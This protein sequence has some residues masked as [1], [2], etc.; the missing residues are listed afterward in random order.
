MLSCVIAGRFCARHCFQFRE[1]GN[2]PLTFGP[3][4]TTLRHLHLKPRLLR[5]QLG[6]L[7][8][9]LFAL[10]LQRHQFGRRLLQLVDASLV[11]D[12]VRLDFLQLAVEQPQDP[13]ELVAQ[14]AGAGG[15]YAFWP[16][17]GEPF[18][19][20]G[21]VVELRQQRLATALRIGRVANPRSPEFLHLSREFRSALAQSGKPA[22]HQ[23]QLLGLRQALKLGVDLAEP[24][25][26]GVA[27]GDGLALAEELAALFGK[28]GVLRLK[29]RQLAQLRSELRCSRVRRQCLL[30]RGLS[31]LGSLLKCLNRAF[32]HSPFG[33]ECSQLLP[34]GPNLLPMRPCSLQAGGK[35]I[36][37]LPR[38]RLCICRG[39]LP[40][41]RGV[42]LGRYLLCIGE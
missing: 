2:H 21:K 18:A 35:F 3:E 32:R 24:A 9:Q 5:R 17:P 40:P 16:H 26:L 6:A 30:Q 29:G 25:A 31:S 12:P 39:A 38:C 41:G 22:M 37:L 1:P 7:P 20:A 13:V 27:L 10:L 8:F 34:G 15:T 4:G 28:P 42:Q 11:I 36:E 33:L 19:L 23:L 14:R